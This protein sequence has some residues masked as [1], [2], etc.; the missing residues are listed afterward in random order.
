[1]KVPKNE[2]FWIV[3]SKL[4]TPL[5]YL[6]FTMNTIFFGAYYVE[7]Q[8]VAELGEAERDNAL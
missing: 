2:T 7:A 4:M 6:L 1:M 3:L 8:I 5:E